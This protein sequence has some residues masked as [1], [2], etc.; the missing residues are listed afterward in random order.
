MLIFVRTDGV[1]VG[2][3]GRDEACSGPGERSVGS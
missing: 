3:E 1:G 2:K